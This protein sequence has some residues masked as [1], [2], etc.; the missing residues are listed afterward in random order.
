MNIDME[1]VVYQA[2]YI[3]ETSWEVCNKV[4][5]I[6]TVITSKTRPLVEEWGDRLIMLGPDTWKGEG[7]HPEFEE[8]PNLFTSWR[9]YA[10]AQGLK[11]K[12]GR[13]KIAGNPIVILIDFTPYFVNKDEI[14]SDLW[15]RYKVD[16]LTGAWDYI[17]PA[18]FGYAAGKVIEC[19]YHFHLTFSD[20]I[21]AQF[22]EWITGVGVL[23][24]DEHVPQI[25]TVFTTHATVVGRSIAGNGL[26]LYSKFDSFNAE[27]EARNFN[28]IA[29]HSL[30]KVAAM[31]A[32]CFTTVSEITA[33]ECIHF[34]GKKPDVLTPNGYDDFI[35]PDNF[36]FKEKRALARK[37][38]FDVAEALLGYKMSDDSILL[39]KSGRYEFRNKG[40]DIFIDT[41]GELCNNNEM[42][43][44]IIAFIFVPAHCTGPRKDIVEKLENGSRVINQEHILTHNL[45]GAEYDPILLRIKQN[46][47][48]NDRNKKVKICFAPVYLS[49][50]DGIFNLTYYELL[51]GFDL[52]AFPSYYEPWGYTP[53]ESLAFHVPTITTSLTGFGMILQGQT[54]SI[55]EG[56][57]IINR[58][59]DN[60]KAV[61][62]SMASTILEFLRMGNEAIN[63]ARESAFLLSKKALWK[64]YIGYYKQA[65]SFA[66][67]KTVD[68]SDLYRHMPHIHLQESKTEME[69]LIPSMPSWRKIFVQSQLPDALKTLNK[70]AKNLWWT[71]NFEAIELFKMIDVAL[72][73]KASYNPLVLLDSISYTQ[74]KR[75][76]RNKD[77][78]L[79]LNQ[80]GTNFNNY[81]N[82]P[83]TTSPHV[84]YFSMEYGFSSFLKLYSGGLGIL[85][86]DYLKEASDNGDNITGIGLLYRKGY[87]KQEISRH[88]EQLVK[89]DVQKF[90]NLP[91]SPVFDKENNWIKVGVAF[92]GRIVYAK[93]WQVEIG[94]VLLYLLDTD[95]IENR[96]EDRDITGNLYGGDWEN[97]L[98]QELLLGIGGIHLL[99][100]LELNPEVYHYN[101]GH[102]A[103]ASLERILN[104]VQ[105]E[106]LSFETAKEVVKSSTLFTTH[107][108]VPAGHDVFKE[109][110][111]RMYLADYATLL[112]ISW[113]R[114][115]SLGKID[116][117][118]PDEKFSMSI[119][120]AEMAQEMNGV[121]LSHQNTS[122]A[123]FNDLWKGYA[124]EEL[125]IGH[126]TN[127]VHFTTWVAL[128]WYNLYTKYLGNG[129]MENL[130]SPAY[131]KKI[132]E[133]PTSEI[134]RV[135][136]LYKMNLLNEIKSKIRNDVSIR[137]NS[138]VFKH[139]T[140]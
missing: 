101:E 22:H 71:W 14:L 127:G 59:D 17:E 9:P 48:N 93:V 23:Y 89:E 50:N 115:M 90:T 8:D 64:N 105:E 39:I 70:I 61:V 116:G 79:K 74:I 111:L 76:E 99:K 31:K 6:H 97:R 4:G 51:I 131:W 106:N 112:N 35:V 49:G 19:Y 100:L 68:R 62:T 109:E 91:L 40:I 18:L 77:F 84:V 21:I 82:K 26:A 69:F 129:L 13:W 134:W 25:G 88:G 78:L 47:L 85:A 66:L 132:N 30:E 98:K 125:P 58:T 133:V 137:S 3:F 124:Y 103:F 126:V 11:V 43:R 55:S 63:R 140:G 29:K 15:L 42:E 94:S 81:L 121:S 114:L 113:K 95:I 87:F 33:K 135:H 36:F 65:Y 54:K 139:C 53:L 41:L 12:I 130:S 16:S 107:T 60:D 1:K 118:N 123:M 45:Q 92:P 52:S 72:W 75:L 38:L 104:L 34:L 46:G 67:A 80:V 56:I 119:L 28:V 96:I 57:A 110:L 102:A 83:R 20:R 108:P 7:K 128:E 24:L 136:Q 73:E 86:G 138:H 27:H 117:N 10:L 44:E 2:D 120:A 5:G 122:R 32:D 37:K